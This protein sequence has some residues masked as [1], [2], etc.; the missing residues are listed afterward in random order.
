MDI[1]NK[2]ISNIS[3]YQTKSERNNISLAKI[4]QNLNGNNM[5][6]MASPPDLRNRNNKFLPGVFVI[7]TW[8]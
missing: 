6:S 1:S 7:A 3:T 5:D 2:I 4:Y 8:S